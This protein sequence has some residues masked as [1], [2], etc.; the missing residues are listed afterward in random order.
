MAI[1]NVFFLDD[2]VMLRDIVWEEFSTP[3]IK[4]TCFSDPELAIAEANK[5]PPDVI[6]IDY[7]LVGYTGELVAMAIPQKITK[8]LITGELNIETKYKFDAVIKKPFNFEEL[9]NLLSKCLGKKNAF[10]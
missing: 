3:E 9:R 10:N 5:N 2:E 7:R 1:L 8:Y 4:I 6:I